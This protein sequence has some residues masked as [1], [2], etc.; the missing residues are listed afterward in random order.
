MIKFEDQQAAWTHVPVDDVG[1]V[2]SIE[3]L[4]LSDEELRDLVKGCEYR[5]YGGWRNESGRWRDVLGLDDT[6]GKTVLDY[7]CGLGIEAL[8][9]ARTGNDV[10]LADIV[11][12]NL[13]LASRV[14]KVFGYQDRGVM[15]LGSDGSNTSDP[16][17]PPEFDVVHSAGVIHHIPE[18][19]PV[20]ERIAQLLKPEGE[21]RLMMYSDMGWRVATKAPP[22]G[23]L[24]PGPSTTMEIDAHRQQFIRFMD[25]VGEW[26]EWYNRGRLESWFG[27]W[28]DVEYTE[29]ITPD[30]RYMVA[31]LVRH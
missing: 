6:H 29:Y 27:T 1:Y 28:F 16:A 23:G 18:P 5:R 17:K 4:Q 2:S 10:W 24:A 11:M 19:I 14:L 15:L 26:A 3:L 7:G 30:Q 8:Q 31:I 22:G 9:Y 25:D 13:Q 12:S 21:L 20:V